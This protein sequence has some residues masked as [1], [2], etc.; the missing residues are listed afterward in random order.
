VSQLEPIRW[1]DRFGMEHLLINGK[2]DDVFHIIPEKRDEDGNSF[3]EILSKK[4][5]IE[6]A[7]KV[8]SN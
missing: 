8:Q 2:G 6:F 1:I 5:L 7:K 3:T 4:A